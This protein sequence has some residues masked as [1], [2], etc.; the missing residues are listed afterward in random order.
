MFVIVGL[1]KNLQNFAPEVGFKFGVKRGFQKGITLEG[2]T[3]GSFHI[4]VFTNRLQ[5]ITIFLH[6]SLDS[7]WGL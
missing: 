1:Q 7:S 6:L 4:L 2:R 3:S 5:K